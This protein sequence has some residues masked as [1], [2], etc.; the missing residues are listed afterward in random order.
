MRAGLRVGVLLLSIAAGDALAARAPFDPRPWMSDL[1]QIR[2]AFAEK[3][4]NLEWAV[5]EREIDLPGLFAR[6]EARVRAAGSEAEAEAAID[7]LTRTLGDGH[8]RVVWP[9][10]RD[11]RGSSGRDG[12]PTDL[13]AALGFD[14]TKSGQAFAPRIAGYEPLPAEAAPE[15]PAG[16]V[17]VGGERL[18]ILRIGL[19][20][21]MGSS[22]LCATALRA[23]AL[24][25][26]ADCDERCADRLESTAYRWMSRQLADRIRDLRARGATTLL[27]DVTENGGGSEWAEAAARIVSPFALRSERLG[28]VRGR[29]WADHWR[30]LA[31]E[32]RAAERGAS[33][34]ER[35]RLARWAA[36]A[37]RAR[38]DARK[39]CSSAPFWSGRRPSC[40]W[41]VRDSYATGLLGE[42]DASALHAKPWGSLV[43]TPAE[44][45]FQQSVWHGPLL[46][47]VDG[48]T[49]SAAGEFAAV[50][51]D[52]RAAVVLG[53][54]ALGG[55]GYTDGG[56]PTQLTHSG[57]ILE[58]PDCAR[59]R[60]DGSNEVA[61]IDPDVLVGFQSI[62]GPRRKARRLAAVL[63][64]AVAAARELC[65]RERCDGRSP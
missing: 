23:L 55:C 54:P 49:G 38:D 18:G 48:N 25:P 56:A 52:N 44:Y 60:R 41:L 32:L 15:F 17:P 39:V 63:P 45:E 31:E 5:F 65:Q 22:Q 29:H 24:P 59:F 11:S 1:Q 46:V 16:I 12:R 58:L 36:Q 37:D 51:Q 61:G 28:F 57:A 3:Y 53:S 64:R 4:A 2:E 8:V 35:Q 6:T 21:P 33:M 43:F 13:C 42:G 50:L 26:G 34:Q 62:D 40:D 20:S 27:I 30:V 9:S 14:D 19:F 47:L 7:R 10:A